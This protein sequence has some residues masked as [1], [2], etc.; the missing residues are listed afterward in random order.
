MARIFEYDSAEELIIVP[1]AELFA[2]PE[3]PDDHPLFETVDPLC[4]QIANEDRRMR[5]ITGRPFWACRTA[6]V[7]RD[8]NGRPLWIDGVLEDITSRKLTEEQL[9]H[10]ATHDPLTGLPNRML[11]EDRLAV[12]LHSAERHNNRLAILMLDLNGFKL[13]NDRFGHHAGDLLLE[14]VADRLQTAL[15]KTDTVARVGGDEFVILLPNLNTP[16]GAVVVAEK[17]VTMIAEPVRIAGQDVTVSAAVGIAMFPN[18][19][20]DGQTL[21]RR[22]DAAMYAAKREGNGYLKR[23]SS[24]LEVAVEE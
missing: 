15:R 18:D 14:T 22:A 23:F 4:S 12:A 16:P 13:V 5:K 9:V 20:T 10:L 24:E 19:G 11:F 6:T 8:E 2:N 1:V 7:K 17:C 21:L 3:D